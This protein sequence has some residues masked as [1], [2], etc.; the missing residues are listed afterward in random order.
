MSGGVIFG[1]LQSSYGAYI[2]IIPESEQIDVNF[3]VRMI[4]GTITKTNTEK[5]LPI[6][7]GRIIESIQEEQKQGI[8]K[9]TVS[10]EDYASGEIILTNN[11]PSLVS[12]VASTRF[13]SPEGLIFRAIEEIK[14]PAK[15][16]V[17]VAVRAEKMGAEYEIG[18]TTF[19]IP[20]L[21]D[22]YLQKNI[23]AESNS[24]MTGGIKKAGII[25][26]NDLDEIKKEVKN[27]LLKK[28]LEEIQ[29]QI[30]GKN[31]KTII[32]SEMLDEKSD[33][34][35]GD[36]KTEFIISEKMKIG[37][38]VFTE[39]DLL[40]QAILTLQQNVPAGKILLDY[41]TKSLSCLLKEYD[42]IKKQGILEVQFRGR[43]IIGENNEILEK[44]NFREA[45]TEQIKNYLQQ[46]KEIKQI[47]VKLS[48]PLL[49]QRAP[50]DLE[51]IKIT[52]IK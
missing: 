12:F 8:P 32:K 16:Q 10:V 3:K 31:L 13:S 50:Y 48:P 21:R 39:K 26:Q 22:S 51:R 28:G 6:I 44:T 14:I 45:T 49:F 18:P 41:E 38:V 34:R 47:Q 2:T 5:D 37:A 40:D 17:T 46:F 36:E 4:E 29:N 20:N 23:V 25:M 35:V 30:S 33:G 9:A 42:L 52:I 1:L 19:T 43:M 7:T 27:N 15:K 24:Q 11:T